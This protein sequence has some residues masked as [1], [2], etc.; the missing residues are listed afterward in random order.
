MSERDFPA[1]IQR[2]FAW[3]LA[4]WGMLALSIGWLLLAVLIWPRSLEALIHQPLLRK[5]SGSW[6]MV[7]VSIIALMQPPALAWLIYRAVRGR[8]SRRA[9]ALIVSAAAPLSTLAAIALLMTTAKVLEKRALHEHEMR[10]STGSISYVCE[11]DHP[12]VDFRRDA[13]RSTQ[14]ILTK[15]RHGDTPPTWTIAWPAEMAGAAAN[16]DA[17]TGSIGG[18]QGIQWR[19]ARG[20]YS[21]TLSFS[22]VLGEYGTAT[23][24]L[25]MKRSDDRDFSRDSDPA[26]I[27]MTCG[28]DPESYRANE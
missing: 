14:L 2:N 27:D 23:I 9:G 24:W 13:M 4:F 26:Y 6:A 1:V 22:D 7:G 8:Y 15:H 16:F 21:A 19:A 17:D 10:L 28:P 18:S 11:K 25:R 12:S 20:R 3:R 5:P